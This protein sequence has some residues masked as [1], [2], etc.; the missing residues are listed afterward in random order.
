M[1]V[2]FGSNIT[3][4]VKFVQSLPVFLCTM[5]NIDM[6]QIGQCVI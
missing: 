3:V 4:H 1:T 2:Y 6:R 5:N